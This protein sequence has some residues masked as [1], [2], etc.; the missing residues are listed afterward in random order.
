M[1]LLALLLAAHPLDEG[2]AAFAR[3]DYAVALVQLSTAYDAARKAGDDDAADA[4]LL[5]LSSTYRLL[6]RLDEAEAVLDKVSTRGPAT[7]IQAGLVRLDRGDL[8]QAERAFESAFLAAQKAEDPETALVAALDLGLARM[9]RADLDGA[10]KA[11]TAALALANALGDP[12]AAADA[13]TDL[14]LVARRRGDLSDAVTLLEAALAD[15]RDQDAVVGEIDASTNLARTLEELGRIDDAQALYASA[16]VQARNR[17]DVT[18][19]A[20][21][22]EGRA[23]LHGRQGSREH[24]QAEFASA[25]T[26]WATAGRTYDLRRATLEMLALGTDVDVSALNALLDEDL[27]PRNEAVARMLLGRATGDLEELNA[28]VALAER[29]V[30]TLR[31]KAHAA[32]GQALLDAGR[33]D[34][35]IEH[36]VEATALLERT[37]RSLDADGAAAFLLDKSGIYEDLVAA[38]LES[39][40]TQAAFLYAQRL[41]LA[42]IPAPVE[43]SAELGRYQALQDQQAWL[44]ARL[45]EAPMDSEMASAL[46]QQL[47]TLHVEFSATVDELRATYPD[48]D[49][50]VRVDPDDLEA[51]QR[52]LDEG[53]LVLQPLILGDRLVLIVVSRESLR[54]IQTETSAHDVERTLSRLTR[55]LRAQMIDDE[56]WTRALCEE[57]GEWLLAP[58]AEELAAAEVLVVNPTGPFQQLP[59]ALLRHDDRWLVEHVAVA[60]VT[61]V[62]SLRSRGSRDPGYALDGRRLLLIGNP[63]GSLPEAEVEVRAIAASQPGSTLLVGSLGGREQLVEFT[64]E[65]TTLHL[66]THGIVDPAHPERSYLLIGDGSSRSGRL[67][68]GEIPGLAPYLSSARLVVLSACESGLPVKAPDAEGSETAI[69]INGLSA[70][71]RRAGVETLVASMWKVDD[72]GTRRLMEGFYDNLSAGQDVAEALRHSQLALIEDDELGHPWF[73]GSFVVMG[74]WR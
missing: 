50:A 30:P 58:I 34:E 55:S 43:D 32:Y 14:A 61:H 72:E 1:L 23:A 52:D 19:Q 26:A 73:W 54:V 51:V 11:F 7:E 20:R 53:V 37:R 68:Y 6:G 41:Q 18:R 70:Q 17:E 40:D 39:G 62:G 64:P 69:S 42:S 36:L 47:A 65:M 4:A 3:G 71:F 29:Q 66:A 63:D 33:R 8:K 22:H 44:S 24:A 5:R 16:L 60:S 45:A 10:D 2:E 59:F 12:L 27:D 15:Y 48:F 35:G 25:M 9:Y 38:Y 13:R 46:R 28:A 56:A 57:L 31:W 49:Q 21:V 74:D 67:S